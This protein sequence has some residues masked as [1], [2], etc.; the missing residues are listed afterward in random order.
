LGKDPEEIDVLYFGSFLQ[1]IAK[2]VQK[3]RQNGRKTCL[4]GYID[5]NKAIYTQE[6][7]NP[8]T[9]LRYMDKKYPKACTWKLTGQS[10]QQAKQPKG[11]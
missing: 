2:K 1:F 4:F 5:I 9:F 7:A 10:E 11:L 6:F 8:W 3:R